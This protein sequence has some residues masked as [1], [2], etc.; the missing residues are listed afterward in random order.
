VCVY[1]GVTPLLRK[2]YVGVMGTFGSFLAAG[3]EGEEKASGERSSGCDKICRRPI[4]M[5]M[6][7]V[8]S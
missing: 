4:G 6:L 5:T 1:L 3:R 2:T 8:R 7:G